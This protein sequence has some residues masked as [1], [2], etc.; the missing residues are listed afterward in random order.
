MSRH[1]R[2]INKTQVIA[3]AGLVKLRRLFALHSACAV[4]VNNLLFQ[5]IGTR[6]LRVNV[7]INDHIA[8]TRLIKIRIRKIEMLFPISHATATQRI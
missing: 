3:T 7:R 6:F 2:I 8:V 4:V 1:D 5:I